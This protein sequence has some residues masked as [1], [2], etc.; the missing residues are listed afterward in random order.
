MIRYNLIDKKSIISPTAKLVYQTSA[1][2][3]PALFFALFGSP[4]LGIQ[5]I[6][7]PFLRPLMFLCALSLAVVQ[8]GMEVFLFRFD[9]SHPLKQMFWFCVLLI[10]FIGSTL[11]CFVVYSRSEALKNSDNPTESSTVSE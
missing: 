9:T 10:P 6:I 7:M 4:L 5:Q 1:I 11:Y 8:I 2:L 3:G